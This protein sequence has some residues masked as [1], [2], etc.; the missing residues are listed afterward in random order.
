[1][2]SARMLAP[3]AISIAKFGVIIALTYGE[4]RSI[5]DDPIFTTSVGVARIASFLAVSMRIFLRVS[6]A[7]WSSPPP[8]MGINGGGPRR[9]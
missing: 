6:L 8:I 1:M 9:T 7:L 5:L 4:V 3:T 2:F